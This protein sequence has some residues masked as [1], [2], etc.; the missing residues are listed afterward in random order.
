SGRAGR[1]RGDQHS[2]RSPGR[3]A[4]LAVEHEP[5]E[6]LMPLAAEREQSGPQLR[7]CPGCGLFQHVPAM[8]R[9]MTARCVRCTTS[10][11]RTTSH[12]LDHSVALVVA[13][14][15]LLI[16]M[17]ATTLMSVET[18][19]IAHSAFLLS[20]PE[21]LVRRGM[22]PLAVV[23]VFVTLIAPLGKLAGTLYVL[24]RL[25]EH[26]PPRHLSKVFIAVERLRPWSM[27]E[28]FVFG[29]FVA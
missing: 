5:G 26:A 2:G 19:G 21:E 8:A 27:I 20:G 23:V 13:A 1:G 28:V 25:H 17:A 24:I 7:E 4:C 3:C 14:L 29:V 16:V 10:L 9:D 15:V 18:A 22:A 6:T 12:P 11:H